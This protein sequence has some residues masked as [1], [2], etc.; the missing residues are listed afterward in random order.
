MKVHYCGVRGSLPAAGVEFARYG[1]HSSCVALTHAGADR[2]SLILDAGTGLVRA[3]SLMNGEPFAGTI[4]LTHLHWDHVIG[5]P[6]CSAVD[7]PDAH[8]TVL[9][10]EQRTGEAAK[11]GQQSATEQTAARN[12]LTSCYRTKD[13]RWIYLSCLQGFH[14]WPDACAVLGREDLVS[15]PRFATHE[16]LMANGRQAVDILQAEFL[17]G[18]AAEWRERLAGFRGQWSVVQDALEVTQDPQAKANGYI[19]QTQTAEGTEFSL[20]ATPVQ[21]DGSPAPAGRAPDFNEHGDAILTD[22]L[23]YD[24]DTVVEMKVKGAVE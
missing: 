12:P 24:W 16:D 23:G 6:F 3:S 19:V 11:T 17:K 7:N 20:V 21:F 10:P 1:G 18:T 5:L 8:T 2:P 13:N 4:L 22:L 15:D 14:Y 9:L